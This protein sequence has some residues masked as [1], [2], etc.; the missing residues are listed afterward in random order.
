MFTNECTLELLSKCSNKQYINYLGKMDSN[1][2]IVEYIAS[3]YSLILK[4]I[5][6]LGLLQFFEQDGHSFDPYTANCTYPLSLD[7]DTEAFEL[8]LTSLSYVNTIRTFEQNEKILN[9]YNFFNN[10]NFKIE[11]IEE[12]SFCSN[13]KHSVITPTKHCNVCHESIANLIPHFYLSNKMQKNIKKQE[14][15]LYYN[16]NEF[17]TI[18]VNLVYFNLKEHYP[19]LKKNYD[20]FKLIINSDL[21]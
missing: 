10:L 19:D 13:C 5:N 11:K 12:T 3:Y 18:I 4:K 1:K 14:K 8:F 2:N 9:I 17:N 21:F 15:Y 7:P 20:K 6:H 16:I